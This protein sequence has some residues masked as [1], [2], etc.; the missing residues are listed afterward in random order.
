[1]YRQKVDGLFERGEYPDVGGL[2]AGKTMTKGWT[3]EYA[4]V[5]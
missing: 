4:T 2:I 5:G 1:M 3:T